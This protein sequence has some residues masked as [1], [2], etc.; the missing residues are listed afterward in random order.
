MKAFEG[1]K[2]F[3]SHHARNKCSW[4]ILITTQKDKEIRSTLHCTYTRLYTLPFNYT[5][6]TYNYTLVEV[7]VSI[8]EGKGSASLK[9]R[10]LAGGSQVS[11]CSLV[12]V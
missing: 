4:K 1:N 2:S 10:C 12:S 7:Q 8:Q 6:I 11:F 3:N 9:W 5:D